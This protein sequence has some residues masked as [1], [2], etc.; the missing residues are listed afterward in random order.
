[1]ALSW[2]LQSPQDTFQRSNCWHGA[3]SP[4]PSH[5]PPRPHLLFRCPSVLPRHAAAVLCRAAR[6][7]H[8]NGCLLA[9]GRPSWQNR[10]RR[11]CHTKLESWTESPA[12]WLPGW[13]PGFASPRRWRAAASRSSPATAPGSPAATRPRPAGAALPPLCR[14]RGRTRGRPARMP[15]DP[16]ACHSSTATQRGRSA[17]LALQT[18]CRRRACR[19]FLQR[20]RPRDHA[21]PDRRF[22]RLP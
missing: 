2:R 1:M 6:A 11:R 9:D 17:G 16:S 5:G 12:E 10:P 20:T 15:G 13:A 22:R 8:A 19:C 7:A 18:A 3:D 14:S 21:S 4:M